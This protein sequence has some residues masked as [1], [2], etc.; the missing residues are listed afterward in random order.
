MNLHVLLIG[1]DAYDGGGS[2]N[3]CVNDVDAIQRILLN[4][5]GVPPKSIKR[6]VSPRSGAVQETSI[7]SEIPTLLNIRAELARLGSDQIAPTDR[8]F[9]YYSGHGTQLTLRD[10]EGHRFPREALLPKDKVRGPETLFLP[11]WELNAAL[12]RICSRCHSITVILDCC[13]SAGATRELGFDTGTPRFWPTPDNLAAEGVARASGTRGVAEN[14]LEFSSK[15][16][17]IAACQA[18]EKAKENGEDGKIMGHLTRVLCTHL[19]A[20]DKSELPE[21]RWGRIWRQVEAEV[22]QRNPQQRPW[23]SEGFARPVFGGDTGLVAD[24]G[25]GITPMGDQYEIDAGTLAGVTQDAIIGVYGSEP[26]VFHMLG[27]QKDLDV[28][29][30]ELKVTNAEKATARAIPVS[31]WELPEGARGRLVQPGRDSALRVVLRPPAPALLEELKS[32][33]LVQLV[34]DPRDADIELVQVDEGWA[35]VDD[36]HDISEN[37]PRFPVI[38]NRQGAAR[39]MIQ[40]YYRYSAPL[41]LA[42]SCLDLPRML[43]ISVLDCNGVELTHE[44]GQTI[45]LSEVAGSSRARYEVAQN[46]LVCIAVANRSERDLYVTLIDVAPSGR[47]ILLGESALPKQA[48]S[49]FWFDSIIGNPFPASVPTGHNVGVDRLVAI[50]TTRPGFNLGHLASHKTFDEILQATRDGSPRD[51]VSLGEAPQVDQYTST[52]AALWI[53]NKQV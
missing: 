1:I 2:L 6:L 3:G 15:C 35:L 13:S 53:V 14:L 29:V 36:I 42:Y 5:V 20:I 45:A 34:D 8:V 47:V 49:R 27:T 25:F 26:H 50:G 48:H 39:A 9:I 32:S 12:A 7:P 51:L 16:Q 21:L 33:P 46:D 18:N 19:L 52:V 38:P 43:H 4:R 22:V 23:I 41:R 30:G 44:N 37:E 11:D 31:E 17:V 10:A 24:I 40:H 28:R